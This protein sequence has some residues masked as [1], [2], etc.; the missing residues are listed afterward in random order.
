MAKRQTKAFEI[1]SLA[2][3]GELRSKLAHSILVYDQQKSHVIHF[4]SKESG[5]AVHSVLWAKRY[6]QAKDF[7]NV[8]KLKQDIQ[9]MRIPSISI[10]ISTGPNLFEMWLQTALTQKND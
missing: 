3:A 10:H 7:D 2:L 5:R 9:A 1:L 4:S 6:A 8:Y